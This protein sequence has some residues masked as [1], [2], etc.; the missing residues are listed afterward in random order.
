MSRIALLVLAVAAS[1][2]SGPLSRIATEASPLAISFWRVALASAVLLPLALTRTRRE[3]G[4]LSRKDGALLVGSATLLALHFVTWIA[5]VDLTSVASSVLL[6]TSG[7]V[8][9]ALASGLMGERLG[10]RAWIGIALAIAGGALVAFAPKAAES[11]SPNALGGN[12]LALAGAIA[13]AGYLVIGRVMRPRVSLLLYIGSVYAICAAVLLAG[14]L[15]TR[16]PLFGFSS[17]T[18]LAILGIAAG[19]QLIAH[20]IFNFLLRDME[21]WKVAAVPLAEPI[22]STIIAIFLFSEVPGTLVIPGGILLLIGVW[23][24]LTAS[25]PALDGR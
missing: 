12:A 19:P 9:I 25:Y 20:T 14:A 11:V 4:T 6:V 5:S 15:V 7:P 18:W 2:W 22:G 16:T 1:S 21:A 17:G 13:V 8:W 24:S 23:L 10:P 3:W